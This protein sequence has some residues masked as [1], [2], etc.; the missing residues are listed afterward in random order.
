MLSR[1]N[2]KCHDGRQKWEG[3]LLLPL[4][5]IDGRPFAGTCATDN[6]FMS[7]QFIKTYCSQVYASD[8]NFLTLTI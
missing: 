5:T 2:E 3:C 6:Y 7:S 8:G 1:T 4:L